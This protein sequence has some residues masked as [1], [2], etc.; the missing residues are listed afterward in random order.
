MSQEEFQ[1]VLDGN[2]AHRISAPSMAQEDSD[3]RLYALEQNQLQ[4]ETQ[5]PNRQTNRSKSRPGQVAGSNFLP[6]LQAF[7]DGLPKTATT[8]HKGMGPGSRAFACLVSCLCV[9]VVFVCLT[10]ASWERS[11]RTEFETHVLQQHTNY[12]YC[13]GC[14][15][16][17]L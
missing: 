4:Y 12:C 15:Q 10:A 7:A 8:T 6:P 16:V 5:E 17:M 13:F 11:L 3:R 1:L 2:L 14:C 9:C